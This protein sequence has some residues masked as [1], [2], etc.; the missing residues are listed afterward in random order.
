VAFCKFGLIF[1]T[2]G[3]IGQQK[4]G[5]L[6]HKAFTNWK[7]AKEVSLLVYNNT[8]SYLFYFQRMSFRNITEI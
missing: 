1:A 6:T 8:L 7:N 3:N 4:L 5:V 2:T